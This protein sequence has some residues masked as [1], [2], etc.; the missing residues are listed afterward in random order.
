MNFPRSDN[1]M[2]LTLDFVKYKNYLFNDICQAIGNG[3]GFRSSIFIFVGFWSGVPWIGFE[4][5]FL[6]DIGRAAFAQFLR[7]R[8]R[9]QI[10]FSE[11]GM[12]LN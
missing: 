9:C 1:I 5:R 4:S 7:I 2:N 11:S 6:R 8:S 10:S 12:N 3:F